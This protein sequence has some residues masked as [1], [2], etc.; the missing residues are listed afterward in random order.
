M[1]TYCTNS[2]HGQRAAVAHVSW[3]DGRFKP[4]N[5]CASCVRYLL[6]IYVL[7]G[8]KRIE[9]HPALVEPL[10]AAI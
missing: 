2:D 6:S 1:T 3:P 4:V 8:K 7:P 10:E 9:S 5:A